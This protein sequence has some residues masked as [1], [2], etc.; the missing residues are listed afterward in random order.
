MAS[1]DPNVPIEDIP[2]LAP[3]PGVQPNF[4]N[5]PSYQ[6]KIIILEG[7]FVPLMLLAVF[8]RI[9]VRARI[10]RMVGW[11]DCK[12]G[13]IVFTTRLKLNLHRYMYYRCSS[14]L[15]NERQ[16]GINV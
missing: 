11:D 6:H 3:P 12:S 8:V 7:V 1:L 10:T 2:A 4:V 5:P 15:L 16:I 13:M 14:Y 9:F